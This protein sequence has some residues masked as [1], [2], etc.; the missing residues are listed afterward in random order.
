LA[1]IIYLK[2]KYFYNKLYIKVKVRVFR[3]IWIPWG[4]WKK[5]VTCWKLAMKVECSLPT[6]SLF[7][8]SIIPCSFHSAPTRRCSCCTYFYKGNKHIKEKKKIS[9]GRVL[10]QLKMQ[11]NPNLVNFSKLPT[12]TQLNTKFPQSHN[13]NPTMTKTCI[14]H[15]V[16]HLVGT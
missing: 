3:W 6:E 4:T 13:L 10:L 5:C 14:F 2:F 16:D 7:P 1:S 8:A 11:V 15:R 9:V 12:K